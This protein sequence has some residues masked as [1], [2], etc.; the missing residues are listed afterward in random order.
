MVR[1]SSCSPAV[2]SAELASIGAKV[3][4]ASLLFFSCSSGPEQP[5]ADSLQHPK[6]VTKEK[7]PSRRVPVG[8]SGFTI[9]L[10]STHTIRTEEKD[11]SSVFYILP[12]DSSEFSGEAGMYVGPKPQVNPPAGDYTAQELKTNFLGSERPWIEYTMAN[13]IQRETFI[14]DGNGKFIH[15]WCYAD[16]LTELEELFMMIN[17]IQR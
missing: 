1:F 9:D 6:T 7:V 17:S 2:R 12:L 16:N 3:V 14:D 11:S 15:V 4:A 13:F 10:P 5:Q 8:A